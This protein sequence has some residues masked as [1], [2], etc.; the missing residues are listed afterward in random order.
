MF[1]RKM[2][3]EVFVSFAFFMVHGLIRFFRRKNGWK[4]KKKKLNSDPPQGSLL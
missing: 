1:Q 4:Q 3:Y 2:F